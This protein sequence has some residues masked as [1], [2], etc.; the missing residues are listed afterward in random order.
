MLNDN[1]F[2]RESA[3]PV[4]EDRNRIVSALRTMLVPAGSDLDDE[5]FLFV[6][7]NALDFDTLQMI[8]RLANGLSADLVYL[9]FATGSAALRARSIHVVAVRDGIHHLVRNCDLWVDPR[10]KGAVIVRPSDKAGHLVCDGEEFVNLPGK[11]AR[12]LAPGFRRAM[13]ALI[14]RAAAVPVIEAKRFI[15]PTRHVAA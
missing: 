7:G 3:A 12:S 2:F 15:R 4:Q 14:A 1:E 11:P 6:H 9:E 10:G 13:N 8:C 5:P